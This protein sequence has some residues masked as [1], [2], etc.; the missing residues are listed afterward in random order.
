M[1]KKE[2]TGQEWQERENYYMDTLAKLTIPEEPT[3]K[4]VLNLTSKLDKLYTE[5][6]FEY[7]L[8]K[9]KES[10]LTL[11]I[12]NAEAEMFNV[13]KQQQLTSGLKVTETD[14]KGLVK[15]Y[16]STNNIQGYQTDVYTL[17]KAVMDRLVFAEQVVKTIAEKKAAII[18]ATA[19]LKIENSFSGSKERE[20]S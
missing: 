2:Y 20:V 3:V 1:I 13:I 4:E 17:I 5:A 8:L 15:T 9:R 6:S 16:L 7:A 12:K 10:R 18:S 14:V 19:M 11:D